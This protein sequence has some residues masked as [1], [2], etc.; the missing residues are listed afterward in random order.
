MSPGGFQICSWPIHQGGLDQRSNEFALLDSFARPVAVAV[1]A[2][3][4]PSG[5]AGAEAAVDAA[6]PVRHRRA[7]AWRTRSRLSPAAW[8]VVHLRHAVRQVSVH[9]VVLEIFGPPGIRQGRS[10]PGSCTHVLRISIRTKRPLSDL[11]SGAIGEGSI[12]R[13]RETASSTRVSF[14]A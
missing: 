3:R 9:R 6:F 13:S 2:I 7:P 14:R 8:C 10:Y 12:A 4:H 1:V 11:T 5:R